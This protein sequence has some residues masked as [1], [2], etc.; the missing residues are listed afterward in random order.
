MKVSFIIPVYNA[1]KTIARCIQSIQASKTSHSFEIIVVDN[2][3]TDNTAEVLKK[4]NITHLFEPVRNRSL[5]RNR[6]AQ[7]AKGEYLAFIDAD[8][9]ISES[10]LE[11]MLKEAH[12]TIVGI[13]GIIELKPSGI[14]Q[15][16]DN[17][18]NFLF[19]ERK[20]IN[21][22]LLKM[23]IQ[24]SPMINSASCIY[25]KKEFLAIGGFDPQLKRHEDIDLSKRIFLTGNHLLCTEARSYVYYDQGV[26]EYL[27]RSFE[28]G[29]TKIDYFNKW[30]FEQYSNVP[31]SLFIRFVVIMK[32]ILLPLIRGLFT[33]N[34]FYCFKALNAFLRL[35]GNLRGR[36]KPQEMK[37]L[38]L[39]RKD[40]LIYD[41][42]NPIL[43]YNARNNSLEKIL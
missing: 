36:Y 6:G 14:S 40:S 31:H 4:F 33:L 12:E 43:R 7:V 17:Y 10:W 19:N 34:H 23:K 9:I 35:I 27:M 18:R 16:L 39:E 5:A 15:F 8:V 37:A 32:L 38:I 11:D 3:S 22:N 30:S 28:E 1:D 20:N 41:G 25:R 21:Y 24:E 26:K 13:Q 42:A 29:I 2:N